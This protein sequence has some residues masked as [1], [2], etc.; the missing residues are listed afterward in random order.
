MNPFPQPVGLCAESACPDPF[1]L[2]RALANLETSTVK[3]LIDPREEDHD[4]MIATD[5]E[6]TIPDC[7]GDPEAMQGCNYC[8]CYPCGCGG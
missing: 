6:P 1:L 2:A 8:G 3:E 4:V 7:G 5:D